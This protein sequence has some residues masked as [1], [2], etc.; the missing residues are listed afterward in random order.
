MKTSDRILYGWWHGGG[1]LST[2]STISKEQIQKLH[3]EGRKL[4][5]CSNPKLKLWLIACH[6][7][8]IWEQK[9]HNNMRDLFCSCVLGDDLFFKNGYLDWSDFDI[10]LDGA[11]NTPSQRTSSDKLPKLTAKELIDDL[12]LAE[13]WREKNLPKHLVG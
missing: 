2:L 12:Q 13:S 11:W 5:D 6:Y 9:E 4:E 1:G 10:V 3:S 8:K 7:L